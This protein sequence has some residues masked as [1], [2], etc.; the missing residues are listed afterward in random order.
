MAIQFSNSLPPPS[1]SSSSCK[2][3]ATEPPSFYPKRPKDTS[4]AIASGNVELGAGMVNVEQEKFLRKERQRPMR[5]QIPKT[6]MSLEFGEV[7]KKE[8]LVEE[9]FEVEGSGYWLACRKGTR[10]AMEDGYGVVTNING[11]PK[12]VRD[13]C[14]RLRFTPTLIHLSTLFRKY[15]LLDTCS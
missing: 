2:R 8:G 13:Y 11:D 5:I 10:H 3:F 14:I 15:K 4:Y 7:G 6:C 12:Q 1:P 9:G